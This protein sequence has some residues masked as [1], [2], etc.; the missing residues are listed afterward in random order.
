MLASIEDLLVVQDRDRRLLELQKRIAAVPDEEARAKGRLAA[1]EAA[2]AEAKAALQRNA[3]GMNKLELDIETRRTTIE[4]LKKQQ[5][6]TRKNEEF[7][8]LGHEVERYA[9]EIDGLETRELELMEQA[10]ILRAALGQA[11]ASLAKSRTVVDDD[12]RELAVRRR[13]LEADLE[14]TR[15]RRN[16][17]VGTIDEELL[18]L[19][20]RLMK[21]KNGLAVAQVQGG[22]CGG[23]H[24]RLIPT[25]LIKVQSGAEITQ[26]ENCGRILHAG[27]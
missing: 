15:S 9:G 22:Q 13:N 2:V 17:A 27:D 11:E 4:R 24:V 3:V 25:T 10:D 5:F 26:C 18:Q 8:A 21:N 16:E 1:D 23:C 12:L 19:Y 14:E 20:E 6:E 7:R